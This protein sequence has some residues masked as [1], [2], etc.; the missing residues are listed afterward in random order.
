MEKL[1]ISSDEVWLQNWLQ[2]HNKLRV[3]QRRM[4]VSSVYE[5][6]S[7]AKR[8]KVTDITN[9]NKNEPGHGTDSYITIDVRVPIYSGLAVRRP[10][11][12]LTDGIKR[13]AGSQKTKAAL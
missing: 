5:N 10:S 2:T 7:L 11:S 4:K 1:H 12:R 8:P 3:T 9:K 6:Q 13:V